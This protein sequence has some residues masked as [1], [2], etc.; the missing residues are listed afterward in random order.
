MNALLL[1]LLGGALLYQQ[2]LLAREQ[3]AIE[4]LNRALDQQKLLTEATTRFDD[5]RYWSM[6]MVV[7]QIDTS[8]RKAAEARKELTAALDSPALRGMAWT[9]ELVRHLNAITEHT[10]NIFDAA[11][12]E[13]RNQEVARCRE[14]MADA[15]S[16][17][18]AALS[19]QQR[20][21]SGAS[22]ELLGLGRST[23]RVSRAVLV[24]AVPSGVFLAWLTLRAVT[25]P[26]RK[27]STHVAT[28]ATGDLTE[29][30]TDA[31]S[32][33]FGQLMGSIRGMQEGMR[34]ALLS[35]TQ[36][37]RMLSE[38]SGGLTA[39]SDS[40]N[41][42]AGDA[43]SQAARVQTSSE[44]LSRNTES[45]AAAAGQ[46]NASIRE[47]ARN[48]ARAS[49]VSVAA[50]D[51]ADG[52]NA[53]VNLLGSASMEIGKVVKLITSI[54]EQT[55]LLALNATIEAARAGDV[56]RGFGVVAGEVKELAR[57][58]ARATEEITS[59]ILAIQKSSSQAIDA[60]GQITRTVKEISQTQQMIATAVEE[61]TAT[62]NEMNVMFRQTAHDNHEIARSI[63]LV[64]DAARGASGGAEE[65]RKAAARLAEI[66]KEQERLIRRFKVKEGA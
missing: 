58:T 60:I 33:E 9:A 20:G 55:N 62:T 39:V 66:A 11:T 29:S 61:Q 22:A 7:T 53:A 6:D 30:L 49:A 38:A 34:E 65:T 10:L 52:A 2:I 59:Q 25:G 63:A 1:G 36:N 31:R 14:R 28:L 23:S 64:A 24:I 48:A 27:V 17:L 54:A 43:S 16:L 21:A 32:D 44:Q 19:D 45:V 51:L 37:A 50:V 42:N 5:F 18:H 41:R 57:K 15:A 8:A 3:D 13:V 4:G 26:L 12:P 35:I 56:G 46:M 40:M 47:V